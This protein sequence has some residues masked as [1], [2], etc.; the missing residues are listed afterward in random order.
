MDRAGYRT[1]DG[2]RTGEGPLAGVVT[3]G[4]VRAGGRLLTLFLSCVLCRGLG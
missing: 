2:W 3:F 1:G 4:P